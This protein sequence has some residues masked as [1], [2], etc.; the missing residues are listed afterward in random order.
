MSS[1]VN[2]YGK[3]GSLVDVK[4]VFSFWFGNVVIWNVMVLVFV[5]KGY[6]EE[7]L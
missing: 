1:F 3:C 4:N 7:V 2:M 6:G 5:E